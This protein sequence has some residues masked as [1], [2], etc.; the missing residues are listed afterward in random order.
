M[1]VFGGT[2][3]IPATYPA[4]HL[5]YNELAGTDEPC[6]VG[7]TE[8]QNSITSIGI[9][10]LFITPSLTLWDRSFLS[11]APDKPTNRRTRKSI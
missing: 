6:T 9:P 1:P 4:V 5:R 10:R 11:Y 7:V 2:E 3:A 8:P